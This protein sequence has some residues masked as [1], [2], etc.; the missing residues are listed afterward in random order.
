MGGRFHFPGA[1]AFMAK[2]MMGVR[3]MDPNTSDPDLQRLVQT[4]HH[5][6]RAAGLSGDAGGGHL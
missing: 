1:L 2:M 3:V 4:V 5:L 6:A